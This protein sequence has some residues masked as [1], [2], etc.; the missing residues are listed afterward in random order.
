MTWEHGVMT[1]GVLAAGD[2]WGPVAFV[3]IA[4]IWTF[5]LLGGYAVRQVWVIS[6]YV[7][8]LAPV[9]LLAGARG[10]RRRR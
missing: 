8:P 10:L 9:V 7:S 3:G 4:V 5:M 1:A 6:R 2:I